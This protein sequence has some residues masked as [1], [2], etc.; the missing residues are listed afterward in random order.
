MFDSVKVTRTFE[1]IISQIEEAILRNEL[2]A[3]DKLPSE[4]HLTAIFK[5][6]RGTLR[7]ALRSLEQRKLITIKTG[8]RGGAIVREVDSSHI[9]ESLDFLLRYQKITITELME[10]REQVEGMIASVAARKVGKEDII[11]LES[12][13]NSMEDYLQYGIDKWND[14]F[15]LDKK[16]HLTLSRATKNRMYE[17]VLSTVYD[18]INKYF[19]SYLSRDSKI[20]MNTYKEL[21]S[22]LKAVKKGDMELARVSMQ[23]H[24]RRYYRLMKK[25]ERQSKQKI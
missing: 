8:V 18:N 15:D 5:V 3:G 10:F 16:F 24:I 7:E 25:R 22:V 20:L 2:H 13:M 11:Q 4:R 23:N 19:E 21:L 6:S 12:L 1:D 17:S 14:I 9:N